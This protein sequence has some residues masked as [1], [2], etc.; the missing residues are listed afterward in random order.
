MS[1]ED[2]EKLPSTTRKWC[3]IA[4][5]RRDDAQSAPVRRRIDDSAVIEAL[6]FDPPLAQPGDQVDVRCLPNDPVLNADDADQLDA[7]IIVPIDPDYSSDHGYFKKSCR[8][9]TIG[10]PNI[11]LHHHPLGLVQVVFSNCVVKVR[12]G[13]DFEQ[14]KKLSRTGSVKLGNLESYG[15]FCTA[16]T[17]LPVF[18]YL[19]WMS[20]MSPVGYHVASDDSSTDS[21][22][23]NH[24]GSKR[25]HS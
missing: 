22:I 1:A 11:K 14:L 5:V 19:R 21:T 8:I 6:G 4:S 10:R 23:R 25:Q 7:D 2:D 9:V 15:W 16:E 12:L 3:P 24:V 20:N 17:M 13:D 18:I